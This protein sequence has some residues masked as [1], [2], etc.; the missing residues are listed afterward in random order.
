M[1]RSIGD[2][3]FASNLKFQ[4]EAYLY[5]METKSCCRCKKVLPV[6]NFKSNSVRKGGLQGQCTK[7]QKEYRRENYLANREKYI[8]QAKAK[9]G[10]FRIWWR[11]YKKQF[12]CA[13]C[14][15]NHIACIDFH[16]PNDDKDMSVALLVGHGNKERV[17]KEIAKCIPLCR[18]CHAKK[19]Y[20]EKWNK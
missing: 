18:N 11:E 7:C 4:L 2:N 3:I 1:C 8:A 10:L 12:S 5:S 15:E 19:H 14:G 9:D 17:M 20:N 6:E 16:H 13:E